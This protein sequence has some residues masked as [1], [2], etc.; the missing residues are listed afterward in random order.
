MIIDI[1]AHCFPDNLAN[2]A[3]SILTNKGGIKAHTDGTI[4][5]L[6]RSMKEAGIDKSVIQPIA[7]K[8]EQTESINRWATE[9]CDEKIISFGTIHPDYIPWKSEIKKLAYNGVKGVKL[10]PDYQDFFVDEPK[11]FPIYE[12]LFLNGLIVIFH[13]GIDIGMPEPVHCTPKRLSNVIESFP[14]STIIAAHMG[15]YMCTEDVF[16][17][18]VGKDVYFDTSYSYD[19]MGNNIMTKMIKDHGTDKILFGT[20]SP[21]TD[22]TVE[23]NNIKS[24]ELGEDKFNLIAC[25][26]AK[27]LLK[28]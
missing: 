7:T 10:H 27:K 28:I 16:R 2:R 14:G 1:H 19:Y 5:D 25:E 21:W 15:G 17:Y 8:P 6:K 9:I 22:Q 18:L 11:L 23:V 4:K 13:A 3:V 26:N 20:D 12:E 24:L